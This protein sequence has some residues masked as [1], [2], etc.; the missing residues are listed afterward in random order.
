MAPRDLVSHFG[1]PTAR[2]R[3]VVTETADLASALDAAR[4]WPGLRR[5]QLLVR[6]ALE[7]HDVAQHGTDVRRRRRLAAVKQH[8]G[9]LTGVYDQDYLRDS[10]EDWPA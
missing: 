4:R 2:P 9:A 5:P 1:V 6:L 3:H 10:R 8:S 7:A